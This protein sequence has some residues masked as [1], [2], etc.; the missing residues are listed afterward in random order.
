MQQPAALE[1]AALPSLPGFHSLAPLRP[2]S[3]W[4]A[5]SLVFSHGV[6]LVKNTGR[7]A[8]PAVEAPSHLSARSRRNSNVDVGLCAQRS[9]WLAHGGEVLRFFAHTVEA[10]PN[11]ALEEQRVRLCRILHYMEDGTT[12]IEEAREANSG[13]PQGTRLRRHRCERAI[14]TQVRVRDHGAAPVSQLRAPAG[15]TRPGQVPAPSGSP[16]TRHV[17][18]GTALRVPSGDAGAFVT[19]KSLSV[20]ATVSLYGTPY[21]IHACDDWT[22]RFL[23]KCGVRMPA[24]EACPSDAYH[25]AL[26]ALGPAAQRCAR[27]ERAPDGTATGDGKAR[28]SQ[29]HAA[30]CPHCGACPMSRRKPAEAGGRRRSSSSASCT[31]RALTR[32]AS[33]SSSPTTSR[34]TRWRCCLDTDDVA[35]APCGGGPLLPRIAPTAP[36]S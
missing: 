9:Q 32:R 6:P 27:S 8:V 2:G 11:S 5:Q 21:T 33:M 7:D 15:S 18:A 24:D 34:T 17:A 12:S 14:A 16:R 23:E 13:L 19:W 30:A 35:A 22:R 1:E 20:G 36:W 26:T 4:R 28:C 31:R 3:A 25:E 10:V 29:M